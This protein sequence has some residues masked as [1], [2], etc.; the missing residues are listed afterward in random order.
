M[1]RLQRFCA[2]L[3]LLI[4]SIAAI[5][6]DWTDQNSIKNAAATA[7]YGMM[8][9]Y[10]GNES[11]QIPG[12]LPAPYYWWECGAMFGCL[13][14]YWHYTG[15]TSYNEVV[16]QGLLFQI[17]PHNDFMPPNQTFD[18]GNDDQA[19]WGM[20]A[21]TAAENNFP[22]PPAGDPSWLSLAQ[23]VFNEQVGRWDT[24]TC[25]GGLR[26]QV[27]QANSG[28]DLK[29]S[30]SNGAL[31]QIGAR[32]A[33]YTGDDMYA[34]WSYKIWDWMSTI[35]LI[36]SNYNVYDN[37]EAD[38]LNCTQV[39]RNQWCY[40]AGTMLMGA[41]YLYNYTNGDP[42]WQTRVAGLI[43]TIA[44][45]YFPASN[46]GVMQD[47]CEEYSACNQDEKSF[48]AYLSRWMAAST[49]MAP[50][51]Y[52]QVLSLLTTSAKAAA[53]QCNGDLAPVPNGQACGLKWYLNGTWDGTGGPGQ[54]MA[55]MEV[56]LGTLISNT[57][58]PLTNSTG[59]TSTSNPNAGFNS[60]SIP[61]G[62]VITPPSK[63]EKA[64]A[65]VLTAFVLALVLWTAWF[66]WSTA[67][68]PREKKAAA[69]TSEK[70]KA[71][72]V[73]DKRTSVGT[74][75]HIVEEERAYSQRHTLSKVKFRN[76]DDA[77]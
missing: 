22:N 7:A 46:G 60:S 47:I 6:V 51:I 45:D 74:L 61:P 49:Q 3:W 9:Y 20:A 37:S 77:I 48:K 66:M 52:D 73:L 42:L 58:A 24:S 64:G 34:Q 17:G 63:A 67:W 65:W 53:A 23:A 31:F 11:G 33:R 30:I 18:M 1:F 32:L 10:K 14:D 57:Q 76:L 59:G 56:I 43:K 8:S 38:R 41:S 25:G 54:Q 62:E 12:L 72:E 19:F 70:G 28:Y 16:T 39:D 27:F 4:Q 40:N 36:D 55:A 69:T 15:D 21:L 71:R 35:G 13:I 50:F 29:N 26:W 44:Y 68:E 2:V 5:D 75:P